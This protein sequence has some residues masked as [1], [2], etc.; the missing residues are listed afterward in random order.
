MYDIVRGL[1]VARVIGFYTDRDQAKYKLMHSFSRHRLVSKMDQMHH[2]CHI[3]THT[4]RRCDCHENHRPRRPEDHTPGCTTCTAVDLLVEVRNPL[5]E[6]H[7]YI[8][9]GYGSC[10]AQECKVYH[11]QDR[12]TIS[13]G[14]QEGTSGSR[15]RHLP[16]FYLAFFAHINL[17]LSLTI[18]SNSLRSVIPR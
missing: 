5:V 1:P 18:P 9:T 10:H 16:S 8:D 2:T 3:R 15:Q 11:R 13:D 14:C 4:Q 7:L 6:I 17:I 12:S